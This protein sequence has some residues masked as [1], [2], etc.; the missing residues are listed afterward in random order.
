MLAITIDSSNP[1]PLEALFGKYPA[2]DIAQLSKLLAPHSTQ[3]LYEPEEKEFTI[4]GS[5]QL[6]KKELEGLLSQAIYSVYVVKV[7]DKTDS[8]GNKK[9][10][11]VSKVDPTYWNAWKNW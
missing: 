3:L 11:L 8:Q 7:L 5:S 4:M 10:T 1:K 6:D 2:A 9:F